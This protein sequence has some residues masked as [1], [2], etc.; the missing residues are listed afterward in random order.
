MDLSTRIKLVSCYYRANCSPKQALRLYRHETGEHQLP[1]CETSVTRLI[2][3][4]EKTG[5]VADEHRSGRPRVS[6]ATVSNVENSLRLLKERHPLG[7]CSSANVSD[8]C[9][10]PHSTVKKFANGCNSILTTFVE[11]KSWRNP[12]TKNEWDSQI[13]SF[14][15]AILTL[16]F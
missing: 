13:S 15:D 6:E 14:N 2:Q 11:C 3:R 7:V 16:T 12:T 5:S 10:V 9:Q 8:H 4:F 1:C